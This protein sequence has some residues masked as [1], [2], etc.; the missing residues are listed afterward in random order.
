MAIRESRVAPEELEILKMIK[1]IDKLQ[2][3][4]KRSGD[5]KS[6][7]ELDAI[8]KMANNSYRMISKKNEK[9]SI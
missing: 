4:L 5:R 6:V 8:R 2:K 1:H 9:N 3:N 7:K